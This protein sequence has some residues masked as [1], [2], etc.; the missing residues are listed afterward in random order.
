MAAGV[1]WSLRWRLSVLWV[2]EWAISGAILTY[3]PLYFAERNL[4]GQLG[5]LMAVGAAL[6]LWVAPFVVGQV[7]DRWMATEKYLAIAHFLGGLTLIAMPIIAEVCEHDSRFYPLLVTCIA[8]Y[9]IF[10]F[11][12]VP[13]ASSLTFRHLDD[14]ERQ[15]GSVRVW[16]TVGWMLAGLGLSCWLGQTALVEWLMAEFPSWAGTIQDLRGRLGWLPAP[17]SADSFHMGAILSFA[18]SSF[19]IFLPSTPPMRGKR[20]KIAPLQTLWMFRSRSF[21]LMIV[22]SVLLGTV[23]TFYSLAAPSL[24]ERSGIEANWV[25]AVM[26]IGQIS[27]YPA[28]LLLPFFLNRFGLKTTFGIGMAAWLLRYAIFSLEP[29]LWLVL[30]AVGFHGICHVFIV[31][32]IQL[33]IDAQARADLRASAQNLFAF[34]TMGIATPVGFWVGGK[35]VQQFRTEQGVDYGLFFLIP[36]VVILVLL[37]GFIRWF[38]PVETD[39]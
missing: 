5:E 29:S 3:L 37:G 17:A 19:C 23:V 22:I 1:S 16:G 31:I 30:T 10:Y 27:E 2:L 35:L 36:T 24:L 26:T 15:F 6:G 20:G 18:L 4:Q 7:C 33:F 38:E 8:L 39:S 25:P 14:P 11:P 28:L 12:T 34:L 9:G 13:L 21:T 32:V